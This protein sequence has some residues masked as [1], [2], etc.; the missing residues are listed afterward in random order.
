M[1]AT[2]NGAQSILGTATATAGGTWSLT[3]TKALASGTYQLTA[4]QTDAAGTTSAASVAQNLTIDTHTP[5]S[6]EGTAGNSDMFSASGKMT[7]ISS[8]NTISAQSGAMITD[9][10]SNNTYVLEPS[11]IVTIT[12]ATLANGDIFDLT[13]ALDGVGWDGRSADISS[14]LSATTLN[15]GRDL[16][17]ATHY[18]GSTAANLLLTLIG[19]GGSTLSMFEQHAQLS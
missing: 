16:Q 15:G 17:I 6:S 9:L 8:N 2:L 10:G 14:Y 19:Q 12:G 13:E 1:D 4:T 7:F 3:P 11:S 5:A 18:V